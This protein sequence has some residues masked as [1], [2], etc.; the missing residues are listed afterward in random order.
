MLQDI[1]T[2]FVCDACN[3]RCDRALLCWAALEHDQVACLS[4]CGCTEHVLAMD[5][6]G[7]TV[8]WKPAPR[9]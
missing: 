6:P 3:Q 2:T 9:V 8:I 5:D 4:C 7:D 1:P